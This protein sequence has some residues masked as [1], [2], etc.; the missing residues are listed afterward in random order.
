[1]KYIQLPDGRHINLDFVS[2]FHFTPSQLTNDIEVVNGIPVQVRSNARIQ[3]WLGGATTS[4]GII[5]GDEAQRIYDY[6]L[7]R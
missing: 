5:E 6:L 2:S 4:A 1:M 7:T 3:L